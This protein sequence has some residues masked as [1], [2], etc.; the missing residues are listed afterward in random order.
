M[1]CMYIETLDST[2]FLGPLPII[3]IAMVPR[4]Y[5]EEGIARGGILVAF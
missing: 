3:I 4:P 1:L 5:W 2:I